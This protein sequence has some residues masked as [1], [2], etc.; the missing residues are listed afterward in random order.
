MSKLGLVA[1][2]GIG[3]GVLLGAAGVIAVAVSMTP[4]AP[5]TA[6]ASAAQRSYSEVIVLDE[7][8]TLDEQSYQAFSYDFSPHL[9]ASG[10][11]LSLEVTN[12]GG[13]PMDVF[14][15]GRTDYLRLEARSDYSYLGGVSQRSVY[16]TFSSQWFQP[17]EDGLFYVVMMPTNVRDGSWTKSSARL[18]LKG[19]S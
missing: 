19:R 9:R 13:T 8:V 12:V 15:M 10:V 16:G 3:A 6:Q 11:E 17:P 4:T 2:I 1:G 14:V 7:A 18:V 5:Q